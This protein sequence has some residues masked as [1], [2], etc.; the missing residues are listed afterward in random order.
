MNS[1]SEKFLNLV[2]LGFFSFSLALGTW[3]PFS[4][5]SFSEEEEVSNIFSQ[6]IILAFVVYLVGS[7]LFGRRTPKLAQSTK[8]LIIFWAIYSLRSFFSINSQVD[9]FA[10]ISP[11]LKFTIEVVLVIF[12]SDIFRR[13]PKYIDYSLLVF[14]VGSSIVSILFFLGVLD[15][16]VEIRSGRMFFWGEN[17]N[18]TSSRIVI[19]IIS[20]FYLLLQNPF[21]WSRARYVFGLLGVPLL[22]MVVASGSRGSLIILVVCILV[23]LFFS[24]YKS[25][26]KAFII[27]VS[28]I[29]VFLFYRFYFQNVAD[30]LSIIQ[31]LSDMSEGSDAGRSLLKK[32]AF[33]IFL[34]NPIFGCGDGGFSE[35]MRVRFGESLTVHNLYYYVLA[36]TGIMGSIPFAFFILN[37]IISTYKARH[38]QVFPV[39]IL[40]FVLLLFSKTG[41]AL[42]YALIWYLVSIITAQVMSYK[43]HH[44][45]TRIENT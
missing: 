13:E 17:P 12:L 34:D 2:F 11:I 9:M 29:L 37:N 39:V 10:G 8:Y 32:Q 27:V 16:F 19:A 26:T 43:N 36:T 21:K 3:N 38:Y 5:Y 6:Y 4:S 14:V 33:Q 30:E 25:T 35:Q 40:V 1:K 20:L 28:G 15:S 44:T 18:S 7:Y 22:S 24:G 45:T 23:Y 31:R 41:G 42:T